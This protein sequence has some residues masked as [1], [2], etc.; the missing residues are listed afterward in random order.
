[1]EK[2]CIAKKYLNNKVVMKYWSA[3]SP[4]QKFSL[5]RKYPFFVLF[6]FDELHFEVA[7]QWGTKE[8][9]IH[10]TFVKIQHKHINVLF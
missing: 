2:L 1:M 9:L 6:C 4:Y 3:Q 5:C 7:W 8:V 10:L